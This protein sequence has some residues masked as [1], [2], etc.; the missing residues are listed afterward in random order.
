MT[1]YARERTRGLGNMNLKFSTLSILH[2]P[3][4]PHMN[5]M[6]EIVATSFIYNPYPNDPSWSVLIPKIFQISSNIF[7]NFAL[8]V[9]LFS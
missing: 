6:V 8:L 2:F 5:N 9:M 7:G 1:F 4:A 3:L